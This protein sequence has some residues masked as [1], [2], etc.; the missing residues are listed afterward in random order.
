MVHVAKELNTLAAVKGLIG[1][2]GVK[3]CKPY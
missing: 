1:N 3:G 2:E